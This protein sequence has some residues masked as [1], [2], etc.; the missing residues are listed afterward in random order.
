[1]E[2]VRTGLG[3]RHM[4]PQKSGDRPAVGAEAIVIAHALGPTGKPIRKRWNGGG[5]AALYRV[6]RV[7][8]PR[9]PC[10]KPLALMEALVRDFTEPGELVADPFCGSG[11]TL[12]A[13]VKCGRRAIGWERNEGWARLARRR[14]RVAREQFDLFEVSA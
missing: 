14:L 6:P 9:H 8:K 11:S 12:V 3:E 10:E 13:A 2:P 4:A 5:R 1:M 7:A